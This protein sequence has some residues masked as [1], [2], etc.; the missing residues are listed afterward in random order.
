MTVWLPPQATIATVASSGKPGR[1]KFLDNPI[2]SL[3]RERKE[4]GKEIIETNPLVRSV[5][6]HGSRADAVS[7][8]AHETRCFR[9]RTNTAERA[10]AP[11]RESWR[12]KLQHAQNP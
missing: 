10:L 11:G 3:D 12:P 6:V 7:T 2:N 9:D 8:A 5:M 4:K 1:K